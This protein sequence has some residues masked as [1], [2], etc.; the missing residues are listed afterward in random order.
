MSVEFLIEGGP[1]V[2]WRIGRDLLKQGL[3]SMSGLSDVQIWPSNP[4]GRAVAAYSGCV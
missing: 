1:R 4:E 3:Y 2:L